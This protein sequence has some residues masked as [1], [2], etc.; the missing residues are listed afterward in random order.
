VVGQDDFFAEE[1]AAFYG[2]WATNPHPLD[3][4]RLTV[5]MGTQT[6]PP[7]PGLSEAELRSDSLRIDLSRLSRRGRLVLDSLSGHHVQLDNP[8]LVVSL[9][10]DVLRQVRE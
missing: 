1:M 10:R 5:V 9:V 3:E 8:R 4:L 2:K 6:G 7:P